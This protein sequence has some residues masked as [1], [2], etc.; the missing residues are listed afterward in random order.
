MDD[1]DGAGGMNDRTL[2]I[3]GRALRSDKGALIRVNLKDSSRDNANQSVDLDRDVTLDRAIHGLDIGRLSK[4]IGVG[5][6]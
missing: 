6:G 2:K 3:P 4:P 5:S 1:G